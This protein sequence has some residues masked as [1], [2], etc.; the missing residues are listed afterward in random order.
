MLNYQRV[1]TIKLRSFELPTLL[2]FG[3]TLVCCVS[4]NMCGTAVLCII[5]HVGHVWRNIFWQTTISFKLPSLIWRRVDLANGMEK[6]S[7]LAVWNI[8]FI[9][10]YIGN[11]HPNWLYNIFQRGW[12][13][14][15]GKIWRRFKPFF[16]WPDFQISIWSIW[17]TR[18]IALLWE[19]PWNMQNGDC[20]FKSESEI[21]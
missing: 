14:Q 9:F 19:R 1:S 8:N 17:D 11:N 12:N 16:W 5:N 21:A 15:L 10:P 4:V 13:H 18:P 6:H 20:P 2:F 7:W 3:G